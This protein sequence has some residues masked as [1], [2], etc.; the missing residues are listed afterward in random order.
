MLDG[1]HLASGQDAGGGEEAAP[2][3][4]WVVCRLEVCVGAAV[5][6][7]K[8]QRGP[9]QL[10]LFLLVLRGVD[11]M[12]WQLTSKLFAWIKFSFSGGE[13][14]SLPDLKRKVTLLLSSSQFQRRYKAHCMQ[15]RWYNLSSHDVL[16][17][18]PLSLEAQWRGDL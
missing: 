13:T 8:A 17:C 5:Q 16:P 6:V 18:P 14:F 9:R 11:R 7:A 4:C 3:S 1:W 15:R 12:S 2:S 10:C